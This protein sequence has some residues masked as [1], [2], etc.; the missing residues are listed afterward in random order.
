MPFLENLPPASQIKKLL[1]CPS[2]NPEFRCEGLHLERSTH[3]HTAEELHELATNTCTC[4]ESKTE[5]QSCSLR[6]ATATLVKA[7]KRNCNPK[8]VPTLLKFG[9]MEEEL[10]ESIKRF[11][12]LD[13]PLSTATANTFVDAFAPLSH[14]QQSPRMLLRRHEIL[15]LPPSNCVKRAAR[16]SYH[17]PHALLQQ[18]LHHSLAMS[19]AASPNAG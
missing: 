18:A 8:V 5:R 10:L 11:S 16:H 9:V 2:G 1:D 3:Q 12:L 17:W 7:S 15:R 13:D 19:K 14:A 6:L 4:S